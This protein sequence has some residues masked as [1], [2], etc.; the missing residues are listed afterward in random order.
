MKKTSKRYALTITEEQA[1]T[2]VNA[3]DL[4]QRI[5][6]GQLDEVKFIAVPSPGHKLN[7]VELD[8]TIAILKMQLLG[9]PNIGTSHSIMSNVLPDK[10][11]VAWDIQQVI[12]YRIEHD[13]LKPGEKPGCYVPF[14]KPRQTSKEPLPE[15]EKVEV[16][17]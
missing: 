3:I 8:Q 4:Y 7:F 9:W 5:G 2:L 6:M 11:R 16:K 17:K 1:K 10:F 12:R 13:G 15:I 14:D